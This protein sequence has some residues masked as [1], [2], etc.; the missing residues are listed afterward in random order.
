MFSYYFSTS[1]IGS[2]SSFL[3]SG[4]LV[5]FYGFSKLLIVRY[6]LLLDVNTAVT[7]IRTI[8]SLGRYLSTTWYFCPEL[9]G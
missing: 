2:I 9:T 7:E 6:I 1:V 8:V 4:E 5:K 3:T